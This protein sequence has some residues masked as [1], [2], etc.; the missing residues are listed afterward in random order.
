M[1]LYVFQLLAVL[2]IY[3]CEAF[4]VP[5]PHQVNNGVHKLHAVED[6]KVEEF[7]SEDLQT[8]I[9]DLNQKR[10]ESFTTQPTSVDSIPDKIV[11]E[12]K[13][14]ATCVSVAYGYLSQ[15]P[16]DVKAEDIVKLCDTIDEEIAKDPS[17]LLVENLELKLRALELGRYHL[18]TKLMK[19]D[20]DAYVATASFLSP[21]RIDR[22]ECVLRIF[23]F[24]PIHYCHS[25]PYTSLSYILF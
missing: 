22:L 25:C 14:L 5:S 18:L 9:K 4:T 20:Y 8:T 21:S 23:V 1:K 17:G 16:S 24:C 10:V 12:L 2:N 3:V 13:E 15:N 7:N 11:A 19:A 6:K